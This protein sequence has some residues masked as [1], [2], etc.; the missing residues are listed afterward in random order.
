MLVVIDA[1]ITQGAKKKVRLKANLP[2]A[3]SLTKKHYNMIEKSLRSKFR[4]AEEV[5]LIEARIEK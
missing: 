3:D 4:G 1:L 5:Y 2:D